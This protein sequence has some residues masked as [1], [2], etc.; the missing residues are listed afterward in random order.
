[1]PRAVRMTIGGQGMLAPPETL[2]P[3][4]RGFFDHR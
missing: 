3:I 1:M 4:L 2:A